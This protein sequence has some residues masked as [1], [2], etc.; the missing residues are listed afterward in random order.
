[1]Y[2]LSKHQLI[3]IDFYSERGKQA[4]SEEDSFTKIN[5]QRIFMFFG[6]FFQRHIGPS[7]PAEGSPQQGWASSTHSILSRAPPPPRV[8]PRDPPKGPPMLPLCARSSMRSM[9]PASGGQGLS[10]PS[11]CVGSI[12]VHSLAGMENTS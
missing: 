8:P 12:G 1:M 11:C 3:A 7:L 5:R 10:P 9:R 4:V 6:Q 2:T